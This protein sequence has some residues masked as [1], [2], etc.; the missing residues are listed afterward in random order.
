MS[1]PSYL[2]ATTGELI[3]RIS[4]LETGINLG[5]SRQEL[6]RDAL[7]LSAEPTPRA[8]SSPEH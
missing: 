3:E 8:V 6:L 4:F 1:Q 2:N 5:M 7:T